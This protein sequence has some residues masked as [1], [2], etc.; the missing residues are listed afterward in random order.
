[1]QEPEG[2]KEEESHFEAYA[3]QKDPVFHHEEVCSG[4]RQKGQ[5][6]VLI[7][8]TAFLIQPVAHL[9]DQ[10]GAMVASPSEV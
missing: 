2:Q 7:H 4:S 8:H 6:L 10:C 5:T 3:Q 1:M 9:E